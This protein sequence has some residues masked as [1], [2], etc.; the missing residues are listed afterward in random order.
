MKTHICRA[1]TWI[2][3][4]TLPLACLSLFAGCADVVQLGTAVGQSTGYISGDQKASIDRVAV[5][6][7]KAARPMTDKEEAY[8][9]R[10][11]AATLLSQYRVYPD[12]A[13]TSYVNEITQTV[14]LASER[15]FTYGG[16]HV[17]I[18]DTEE[19]NALSCPG[20]MIFITRGMLKKA[21]NED[22][23]AAILAHEVAH[24][25]HKDGLDAIKK[26]RWAE[27]AT[28]VGSEAA[29][30]FSGADLTQL[31]SL[32]E[33][34]VN[35]VVRTLVVNGYG[36][37]QESAADLSALA[38]LNRAGYDPNGFTGCLARIAAE[39]TAGVTGRGIFAT[40][41]GMSNRVAAANQV[42]SQR[43]WKPASHPARDERFRRV[44][45]PQP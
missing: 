38:F 4:A 14:A 44:V 18:L 20:G 5:S 22:E 12:Q 9:G 36:R 15:P 25:N 29:R 26:S 40:H 17:A 39:E 42:I 45:K 24:V 2:L 13:L 41:P 37:E 8:V 23:L 43:G 10:A 11:V 1:A 27:V 3:S 6:T 30:Q 31:V 21:R 35:D 33:G 32:F 7:E 28:L 19:E 34:S 16:Y